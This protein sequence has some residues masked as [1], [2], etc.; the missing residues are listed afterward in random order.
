MTLRFEAG[1]LYIIISTHTSLA[2]RDVDGSNTNPVFSRFLLTRPSRDVTTAGQFLCF[3]F[4]ISTHTSLAGRDG[5]NFSYLLYSEI[6]T[7][8]SLAGR[9][10][11]IIVIK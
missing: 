10:N 4:F 6:S 11:V 3:D 1:K 8:T 7:H 9:D 5:I 2:G